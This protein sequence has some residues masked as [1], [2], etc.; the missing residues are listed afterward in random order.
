MPFFTQAIAASPSISVGG[1][2]TTDLVL[3]LD[4]GNS[5]SYPGTGTNWTDLVST[6]NAT[7]ENGTAYNS[8]NGGHF[9][10]DGSDDYV[11]ATFFTVPSKI[12]VSVWCSI[13]SV[14]ASGGPVRQLFTSDDSTT[15]VRNWQFRVESDGKVR[16]IVFHTSSPNNV[17]LTTSSTLSANTWTQ[18]SMTVDG[19]Y[20]KIYFNGVEQAS[21]SFPY[22]ILGN[23][24]TGDLLMGARHSGSVTDYLDGKIAVGLIYSEALSSTDLTYNYNIL[25]DR[26]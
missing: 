25:K 8:G 6:T 26:F 24:S 7:L 22:S 19:T 21:T 9:V 5:T 13:D 10:F 14:G 20:L 23:G 17:S 18:V 11:D 16:A 1:V 12:T 4:A 3:H 15:P 2:I